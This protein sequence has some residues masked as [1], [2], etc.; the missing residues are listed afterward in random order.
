MENKKRTPNF[1]KFEVD[2]L[3][4]LVASNSSILECKTTDG[5]TVREKL[6]VW[7][8]IATQFNSTPGVTKKRPEWLKTCYENLKRRLRKDMAEEKVQV[9]KTG[10]GKAVPVSKKSP[11]EAKLLEIVGS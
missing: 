2:I 3:L 1:S 6:G 10:G 9:Y 8:N 4:E 7:E 5:C 11:H